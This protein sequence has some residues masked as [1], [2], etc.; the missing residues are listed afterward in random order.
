MKPRNLICKYFRPCCIFSKIKN[1]FTYP[2]VKSSPMLWYYFH[3][4]LKAAARKS[5]TLR[6][7]L[8]KDINYLPR[9]LKYEIKGAWP[10][11]LPTPKFHLCALRCIEGVLSDSK[12]YYCYNM[13]SR[14]ENARWPLLDG[15][16][17]W[18]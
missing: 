6:D 8:K 1:R 3:Q 10:S 17:S 11:S 2:N 18:D 7:N 12:R 5:K 16:F 9:N 13:F 4:F 15:K 14:S